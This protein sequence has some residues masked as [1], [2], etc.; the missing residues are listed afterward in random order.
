MFNALLSTIITIVIT[1][2][3]SYLLSVHVL[4]FIK[5]YELGMEEQERLKKEELVK[6]IKE[7]IKT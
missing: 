2:V 5:I 6:A 4:E 3:I 1:I 7:E